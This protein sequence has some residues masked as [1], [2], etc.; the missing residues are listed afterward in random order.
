VS[1]PLYMDVHVNYAI[2]KG[3]RSRGVEVLTAQQDGTTKLFD[4]QLLDR[5]AA[6]GRVLFSQD[7]DL[8]REGA[9]RQ[10]SGEFFAGVIYGHQLNLTIREC[11]KDLELI[12]KVL[13]PGDLANQVLY[14]PL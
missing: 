12:A 13:D 4:P 3:L 5:A 2:T 6:L 11:I 7:I 8:L 1:V 9:R 14:L 10:H